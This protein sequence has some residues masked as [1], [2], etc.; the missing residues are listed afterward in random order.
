MMYDRSGGGV[1]LRRYTGLSLAWWHSYKWC[2][3]LVM[4][5]FAD[6]FIAPMFHFL[7]P[8]REFNVDKSRH[9]ANVTILSYIRLA[10]PSF[11]E[12]LTSTL[13]DPSLSLR[14]KTLLTNLQSLCEYFIPTVL[15]LY[16]NIQCLN[17]LFI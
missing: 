5:V 10:Y 16:H 14:G 17:I 15:L 8:G 2:T 3:K 1:V 6:D 4:K 9:T 11:K 13:A 12:Q 7:F